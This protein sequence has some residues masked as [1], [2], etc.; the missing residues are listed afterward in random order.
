MHHL[1]D[2]L[3]SD[4]ASARQVAKNALAIG[5]RLV[6]HLA[7][8]LAS[9]FEFCFGIGRRVGA[10]PRRFDLGV[11]AQPCALFGGL[12]QQPRR[13]LFGADLDL[14]CGI[15]RH[16]QNARRFL[17]KH[18]RDELFIDRGGRDG[19]AL[20]DT[21]LALEVPLALLQAGQFGGHHAQKIANLG[22]VETA[23]RTR[24]RCG[25]HLVG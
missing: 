21:Q 15:A 23:T 19:A 5:A 13:A 3:A 10:A 18:L 7:A 2:L 16:L 8:L 20:G 4:F 24:E 14:R 22:L 17:A 25:R 9:H 11:L 12:A 1:L 6:H